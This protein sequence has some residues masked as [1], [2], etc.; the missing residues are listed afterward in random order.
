MTPP[1]PKN[2]CMVLP[3]LLCHYDSSWMKPYM[4]MYVY[5]IY[6]FEAGYYM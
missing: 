5:L 3:I 6:G 2:V 1:F 4:Y